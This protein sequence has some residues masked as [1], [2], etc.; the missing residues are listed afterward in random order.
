MY[1]RVVTFIIVL[2]I[3]FVA[4]FIVIVIITKRLGGTLAASVFRAR[5][6]VSWS[7]ITWQTLVQVR[8]QCPC[9]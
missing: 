4:S 1:L 6:F 2:A 7:I 9:C 8:V 5:D 3:M